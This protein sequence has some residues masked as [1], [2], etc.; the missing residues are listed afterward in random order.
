[1]LFYGLYSK[2]D[3]VLQK[4]DG[5]ETTMALI[6]WAT[7]DIREHPIES[8]PGC[9]HI[10]SD[11]RQKTGWVVLIRVV[12]SGRLRFLGDL[13]IISSLL[14]YKALKVIFIISHFNLK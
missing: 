1:M 13:G 2:A 14:L 11:I 4:A 9:S 6:Q 8:I 5:G 12:S 3:Y 7:R 10:I